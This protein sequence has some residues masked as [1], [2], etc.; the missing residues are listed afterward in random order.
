M[1]LNLDEKVTLLENFY[2]DYVLITLQ[3]VDARGEDT[4]HI[5][6]I[7]VK[8]GDSVV[9]FDI[10]GLLDT[11]TLVENTVFCDTVQND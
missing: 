7:I 4:P 3:V 5:H 1:P 9:A 2:E 8:I 11:L 10:N 6:S